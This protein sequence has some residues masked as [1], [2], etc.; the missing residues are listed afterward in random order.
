M[1]SAGAGHTAGEDLASL[2]DETAQLGH[3]LVIDE[4]SS[5]HAEA[6]HL[7]A[8]LATAAADFSFGSI[9]HAKKPPLQ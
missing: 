4:L 9:C 5:V 8:S 2:G 7:F 1:V 6:A 3:V